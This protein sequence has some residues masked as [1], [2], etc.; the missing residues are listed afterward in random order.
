M[1]KQDTNML[2]LAQVTNFIKISEFSKL[3]PSLNRTLK[4]DVPILPCENIQIIDL[5]RCF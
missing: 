5:R 3:Q 2:T 1:K 4:T